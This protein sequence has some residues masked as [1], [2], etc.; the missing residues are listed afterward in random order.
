MGFKGI[1][2]LYPGLRTYDTDTHGL[3]KPDLFPEST[4]AI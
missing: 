1:V 3:L 4:K 2:A